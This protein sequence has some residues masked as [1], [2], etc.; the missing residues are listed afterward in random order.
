MTNKQAKLLFGFDLNK[1]Y[2]IE[3]IIKRYRELMK[4]NHPDMHVRED[5]KSLM[6]HIKH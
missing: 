2:T 3:E 4:M 6:K 5:E 1:D